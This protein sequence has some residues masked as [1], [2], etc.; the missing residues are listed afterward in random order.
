MS[1]QASSHSVP[2]CLLKTPSITAQLVSLQS[3]RQAVLSVDMWACT[4]AALADAAVPPESRSMVAPESGIGGSMS[5]SGR[6]QGSP[7]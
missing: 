6:Q 3:K 1:L 2:V 7:G 5:A 4:A